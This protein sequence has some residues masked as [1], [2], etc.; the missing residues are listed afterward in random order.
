MD[1]VPSDSDDPDAQTIRERDRFL[2]YAGNRKPRLV[3]KRQVPARLPQPLA[4]VLQLQLDGDALVIGGDDLWGRPPDA[5]EA[6]VPTGDCGC[7]RSPPQIRPPPW[8]PVPKL[9][10]GS[11]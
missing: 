10:V 9:G 5:V 6:H 8:R 2:G 3:G 11:A 4:P 1:V 7:E